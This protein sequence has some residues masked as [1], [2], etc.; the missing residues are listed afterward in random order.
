M[1]LKKTNKNI[2]FRTLRIVSLLPIGF[3]PF[4]FMM[5]LLFFDER[6]ASKNLMIWGLFTAVNSYPVIL[7]VNL[8]ISNRLYSK[9]KI[10]AYAL[11]LW[12]IILFLYLTFKIS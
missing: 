3:W 2:A 11:L 1:G 7:I 6:N 4:V 10:A 8:L 12:P 9:S 5:S